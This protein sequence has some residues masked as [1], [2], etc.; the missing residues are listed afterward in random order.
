MAILQTWKYHLQ[1]IGKPFVVID[2]GEGLLK[3]YKER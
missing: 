3:L 1:S 2:I